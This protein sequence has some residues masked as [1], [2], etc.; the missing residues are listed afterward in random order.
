[1]FGNAYLR[2]IECTSNVQEL[3]AMADCVG[4]F[5]ESLVLKRRENNVKLFLNYTGNFHKEQYFKGKIIGGE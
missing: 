4:T 3:F 1:M 2:L 5:A